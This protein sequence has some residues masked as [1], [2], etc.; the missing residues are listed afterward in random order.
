METAA[1]HRARRP[2]TMF[3]FEF[4]AIGTSW[5]IETPEPLSAQRAPLQQ[6]L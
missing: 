5:E 2:D 4:D 3:N 1:R 6:K